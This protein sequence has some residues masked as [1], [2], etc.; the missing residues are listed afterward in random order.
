MNE[1]H[2]CY[3]SRHTC[4]KIM[5]ATVD[6]PGQEK[7]TAKFVA[8]WIRR[9]EAVERCTSEDV[10]TWDWCKCFDSKQATLSLP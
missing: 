7:R 2:P 8:D 5:A 4:G 9:G 6:R 3:I 1:N 10:R